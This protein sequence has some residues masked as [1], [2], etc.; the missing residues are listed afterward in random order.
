MPAAA[1]TGDDE[2]FRNE[3]S[4]GVNF[5]SNAGLIGGAFVRS[6]YFMTEHMYQF[7]ELE[8]V[9]VKHPKE[10]RVYSYSTGD[11][12]V[13]G[14]QNYLFVIRPHYGRELVL[15]KK[16]AE[17]GV[18]VNAVGAIG[19]SLGLLIPYYIH[20]DYGGAGGFDVRTEQYDPQIHRVPEN[21]QGSANMFTGL[22]E[23]N[24]NVGLHVKG[25]LSFEY[26]RYRESIA[27]IEVGFMV[28]AYPKELVIIPQ[29]DNNSVFTSVYLNIYYGSRK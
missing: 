22:G 7:G 11:S 25:G 6:S 28:E 3:I 17:S 8:I 19:P 29:T 14:K 15:F 27:G 13:Y 10:N 26:G 21:I 20:Y 4:Y 23:A 24:V 5:N 9:E 2:A 18:Q 12:F 1:Q 16:A